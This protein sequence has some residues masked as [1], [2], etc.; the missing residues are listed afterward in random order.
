[1]GSQEVLRMLR[2]RWLL[3]VLAGLLGTAL[4]LTVAAIQSPKYTATADVF[5]TVTSGQSTGDLA[6][7]STF[8]QDQ[9]R[10]FA[11][12][13]SKEIVLGPVITQLKLDTTLEDLRKN[14]DVSVPLNTSV[15]SISVTDKD[16]EQA[17]Q[18]ANAIANQLSIAVSA[19]SPKVDDVKGAPVRAQL[20]EAAVVPEDPSSPSI[21][22]YSMLGLLGGLVLAIGYL[23]IVEIGRASCRERV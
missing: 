15:I 1:M 9:A 21:P 2:G 12:V 10:N 23:V 20:I 13:V 16:P 8:S 5:V 3:I 6:Q 22:L 19:L 7:G 14:I 18:I 4:A 17:A 11:A